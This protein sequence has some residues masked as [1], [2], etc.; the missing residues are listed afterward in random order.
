MI[1]QARQNTA[2]FAKEEAAMTL[3]LCM[4][5]KDEA[6]VLGRCLDSAAGVFDEIV[7][8][9]TGSADETKPI[10]RRYTKDVYDFAWRQ[11]FAAARNFGFDRAAADYCMWMDADEILRPDDAAA[12]RALKQTLC[13]K[14]GRYF[15]RTVIPAED[16]RCALTFERVRIVRRAGARWR[17]RVH[18]DVF[19]GGAA[20]HAAICVTHLG[21]PTREPF[22]NLRIFARAFAD[23]EKPDARQVYYFARELADCGL[24]AAAA[25]AFR[26]FL[27]GDGWAEDKIAACLA[28]ARCLR[29]LQ[30]PREAEQALLQS[31][32]CAP[33]R[34]EACC[35]L[36]DLCREA[37]RLR[38]AV[39]CEGGRLTGETQAMELD[40][41]SARDPEG[42]YW[43]RCSLQCDDSR[44]WHGKA[45]M[46]R[47]AT[48][49]YVYR[50]YEK[51]EFYDLEKDPGELCNRID[52]PACAEAVARLRERLLRWTVETADTVPRTT[53]PR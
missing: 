18:E 42:L 37:G 15:L 49:K 30:R 51:D 24:Y 47:T 26:Y 53:D 32:A 4:I 31:F 11:D 14:I 48:M 2:C 29:A 19:A 45:V 3:G 39:F 40:S 35:A 6:A 52:D 46:C 13:G 12:L 8:V 44:P 1:V 36:G 50:L 27:Q 22:R 28:L 34:A 7:I 9:D 17:G 41:S 20:A 25:D 16:G 5:V 21:K 23:G 43:P 38:D 10:A 33:P